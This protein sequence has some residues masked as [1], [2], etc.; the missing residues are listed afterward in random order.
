MDKSFKKKGEAEKIE[1]SIFCCVYNHA[2][3]LR[4]CLDGFVMQKTTF[5][6]EIV[7]HDDC[8]NDGSLK[9]I[10]EYAAQYPDLFVVL[11]EN[12]NQYS[13][14]VLITSSIMIPRARGRYYAFCEGDDFW[15][16]EYKLQKQY[17]YMER[18]S[19]CTICY[20]NTIRHDL[21]GVEKNSLFNQWISNHVLTIEEA[22]VGWNTHT[23]S[24]FF[25]KEYYIKPEFGK[26]C[27][28][29][30]LVLRTWGV[31]IG[32]VVV[33]PDI[34][35]VYNW[36]VPGG[37]TSTAFYENEEK[38]LKSNLVLLNYY[39]D[40]DKATNGQYH[41]VMQSKIRELESML[42]LI[43]AG[44]RFKNAK[45][46][47]I[48]V[49]ECRDI[50]NNPLFRNVLRNS[51]NCWFISKIIIKYTFPK[52]WRTVIYAKEDIKHKFKS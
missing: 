12:E 22:F 37:A 50:R 18:D 39:K 36:G 1:V 45:N 29:G 42:F 25:R 34:M 52:M 8:S 38:T 6:F 48:L 7:I 28:F 16:D 46:G 44:V 35:S 27:W 4:K 2:K 17:D 21:G 11:T 32:K 49:E 5:E 19:E 43:E 51:D 9:I 33:L 24:S 30:D 26:R 20:H 3:Y 47:K 13:K 40:Y 41:S 23:S 31:H 15:I 10:E 14:G